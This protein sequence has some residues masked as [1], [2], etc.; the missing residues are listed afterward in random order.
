MA[1]K[2]RNGKRKWEG[3]LKEIN[4]NRELPLTTYS[5]QYVR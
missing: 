5:Y 2:A 1:Y 4:A 3:L